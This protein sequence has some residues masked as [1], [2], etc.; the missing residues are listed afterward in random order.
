M[1]VTPKE[2]EGF[3]GKLIL[4]SRVSVKHLEKQTQAEVTAEGNTAAVILCG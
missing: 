1:T 3:L 4:N 2:N